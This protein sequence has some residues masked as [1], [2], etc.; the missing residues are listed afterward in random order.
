MRY[1][2]EQ[3]SLPIYFHTIPTV[4]P[5]HAEL[6][7]S[8]LVRLGL[9]GWGE[10][11]GYG[12]LTGDLNYSLLYGRKSETCLLTSWA[13]NNELIQQVGGSSILEY[14]IANDARGEQ[15]TEVFNVLD[16]LV[17]LFPNDALIH[18]LSSKR[19]L[20]T[21]LLPSTELL[22]IADLDQQRCAALNK[23]WEL[24]EYWDG[25]TNPEDVIQ[26]QIELVAEAMESNVLYL[27]KDVEQSELSQRLV[28]GMN[29][30]A[31]LKRICEITLCF[32][33]AFDYPIEEKIRGVRSSWN[34]LIG[35]HL[36]R[37]QES[38]FLG[39]QMEKLLA[40]SRNV[41]W[42]DLAIG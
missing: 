36:P 23:I 4:H 2:P 8:S 14:S 41:E 31:M 40:I 19:G 38:Q 16:T 26:Q 34:N 9:F 32:D 24:V 12:N 1:H 7:A 18:S 33:P 17:E 21:Q 39:E 37:N 30:N 10:G 11:L 15:I 22:C 28:S 5:A 27:N 3:L 20:L 29:W 25:S 13:N 35:F 6:A 42:S